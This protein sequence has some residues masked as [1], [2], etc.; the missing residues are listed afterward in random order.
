MI[1]LDPF[2]LMIDIDIDVWHVQSWF[3]WWTNPKLVGGFNPSEQYEFVN[4]D[5]D[6]PNSYGNIKS[7]QIHVPVTTNQILTIIN[8]Q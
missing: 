4:W 3:W 2:I 1:D 7:I 6:I 5:D 8:H